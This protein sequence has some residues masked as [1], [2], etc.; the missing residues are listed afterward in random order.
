MRTPRSGFHAEISYEWRFRSL[1]LC[2]RGGPSSFFSLLIKLAQPILAS[3]GTRGDQRFLIKEQK[4]ATEGIGCKDRA[5]IGERTPASAE[6]D[7]NFCSDAE[8]S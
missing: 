6:I 1:G 2:P 7:S 8:A 5:E 4:P 3:L